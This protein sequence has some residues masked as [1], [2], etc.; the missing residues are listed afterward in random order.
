LVGFIR[1]GILGLRHIAATEEVPTLGIGV[2]CADG[3]LQIFNGLL[4]AGVTVAL[5][6]VQPTQLLQDLGMVGVAVQNTSVCLLG[7][8]EVLLLF[9]DMTDLE[10]NVFLRKG[11][12]RV[13]DNILEALQALVKLLLLFVY[14]SQSEID[15][16]RLLEIRSHA[17][18][19]GESL[20]CVVQRAIAIIKDTNSVPQ[21]GFLGIPEVIER[22]LVGSIR[23]LQVVHHKMAVAQT[24]PGFTACR[25][26]FQN[27]LKI[28]DGLGELFL[29]P[30]DAR[31]GIHGGDGP[32]VVA[33][34]LFIRIHG[35]LK[36]AEQLGQAPDLKP[37]LLIQRGDLLGG[38]EGWTLLALG[39]QGQ[40]AVDLRVGG[41][42]TMV[43]GHGSRG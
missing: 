37:H 17:H 42:V 9:V 23:F 20:L 7:R 21:L 10:P 31:D 8:I 41:E 6:V 5:L 29:G 43:R 19:L 33:Q 13:G 1:L 14:D 35:A 28:L 2:V 39:L 40:V 25:V 11:T 22:L 12:R 16:I 38:A 24:T 18:D 36:I 34:G 15:F 27:I 4:L 26:E 3:L 30:Q 32:L